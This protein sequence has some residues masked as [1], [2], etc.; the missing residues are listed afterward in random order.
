MVLLPKR[1]VRLSPPCHLKI[2]NTSTARLFW[3]GVITS[4]PGYALAVG[5]PPS[6]V[7]FSLQM[8]ADH[9]GHRRKLWSQGRI[10]RPVAR[11]VVGVHRHVWAGLGAAGHLNRPFTCLGHAA[12]HACADAG[13]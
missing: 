8:L 10:E 5:G 11:V 6:V 2:A 3:L 4:F 13:Q 12:I 7:A 9:L 1:T